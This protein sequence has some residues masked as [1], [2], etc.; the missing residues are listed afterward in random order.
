LQ[1]KLATVVRDLQEKDDKG[2]EFG[3]V[4]GNGGFVGGWDD[5]G[6]RSPMRTDDDYRFGDDINEY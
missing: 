6:L 5:E 1:E 4:R 3:I 2:E